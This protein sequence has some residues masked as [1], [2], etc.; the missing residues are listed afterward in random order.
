MNSRRGTKNAHQVRDGEDDPL[1]Q[2]DETLRAI[3]TANTVVCKRWNLAI[4]W[5][6]ARRHRRYTELSRLLAGATPKMLTQRLRE[7]ERDGLVIRE[8]QTSGSRHV[9]YALTP[10]GEG[11]RAVLDAFMGWGRQYEEVAPSR[12]L[13]DR[14]R[15]LPHARE[16]DRSA[17]RSSPADSTDGLSSPA[18]GR[19]GR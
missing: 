11:L 19:P 4:L 14:A 7:L 10:M 12:R 13:H 6:L 9:V 8:A 15:P 1:S 18:A 2:D 17:T 3:E 16:D 5:L